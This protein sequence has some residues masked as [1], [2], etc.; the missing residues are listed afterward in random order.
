MPLASGAGQDV[1]QAVEAAEVP[2]G[3][4]AIDRADLVAE[5]FPD[6]QETQVIRELRELTLITSLLSQVPS[7]LLRDVV[8]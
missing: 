6:V 8:F 1:Y 3:G 5:A 4:G 7:F 2:V